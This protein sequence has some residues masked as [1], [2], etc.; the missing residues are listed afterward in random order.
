[1]QRALL[2]SDPCVI[3]VLTGQVLL[4]FWVFSPSSFYSVCIRK[5]IMSVSEIWK[6]QKSIKKIKTA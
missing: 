6:M 3:G 5:I 2:F 4:G 1:M